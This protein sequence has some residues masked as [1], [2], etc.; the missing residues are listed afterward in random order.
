MFDEVSIR[1]WLIPDENRELPV[2]I[3]GR[4]GGMEETEWGFCDSV[5]GVK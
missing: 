1:I 3:D 4:G 5:V 2:A